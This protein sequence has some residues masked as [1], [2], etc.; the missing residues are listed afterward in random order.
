[1]KIFFDTS[2]LI[3]RYIL[4]IGSDKIDSLFEE[5]DDIFISEITELEINSALKRRVIEKSIS[6]VAYVYILNEFYED[7]EDFNIVN[8]LLYLKRISVELIKKHQIKTLDSL[9]LGSALLSP[10]DIFVSADKKLFDISLLEFVNT[11]LFI[12]LK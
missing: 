2:A 11:S 1:M 7:L 10:A 8:M 6:D 4:E 5:C 3:K 12:G 9:Q